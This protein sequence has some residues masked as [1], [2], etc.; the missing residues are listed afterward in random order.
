MARLT[1][2]LSHN[3]ILKAKPQDKDYTLHDGDGLFPK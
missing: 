2:P 3:E 1:R